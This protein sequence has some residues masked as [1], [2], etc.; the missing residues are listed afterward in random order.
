MR[1]ECLELCGEWKLSFNDETMINLRSDAKIGW[2]NKVI[3]TEVKYTP[4]SVSVALTVTT[5]V[6]IGTFS[7]ISFE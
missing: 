6:P 4:E 1:C 7:K 5:S 3:K 2:E